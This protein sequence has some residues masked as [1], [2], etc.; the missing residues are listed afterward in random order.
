MGG[1]CVDE[2]GIG[3]S[4]V[5]FSSICFYYFNMLEMGKIITSTSCKI[6]INLNGGHMP[7]GTNDLGKNRRVVASSTTNVNN[8]FSFLQVQ[9]IDQKGQKTRLA[10]IGLTCGIN[11]N[12]HVTV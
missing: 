10:I 7:V 5:V 3:W 4:R 6:G 8:M 12:E 11:F 1:P 9:C 2:N